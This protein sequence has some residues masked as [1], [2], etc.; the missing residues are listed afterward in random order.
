MH[1]RHSF[2]TLIAS[3]MVVG[4]V[5]VAE[6][7]V[8]L[9]AIISDSMV[10][11]QGRPVTIW[12]WAEPGERITIEMDGKIHDSGEDLD[13]PLYPEEITTTAN[14]QGRWKAVLRSRESGEMCEMTLTDASG[15][16]TTI[17]N[18]LTGEVWLCSGQS[19]MEMPVAGVNN[20]KKEIAAAKYPNIRFFQV[21]NATAVKPQTDCEGRWVE[22]SPETVGSH[23]AVGYFFGRE[24]FTKLNAPVGLIESDW[25]GTPAEA[26]TSREALDVQPSLAPLLARWDKTARK[27]T[28]QATAPHRPAN[29]YNAMIAPIA[30]YTIRG[31]IWYQ[32]ESNTS[33]AYQYRT[34]FPTMIAD[35]RERFKQPDMPFGFVQIAPYRYTTKNNKV[36]HRWCAELWE[37][38]LLTLKR[39]RNTGMVVTTDIGEVKNIHPKNKQEVGRR[40]ALWALARVYGKQLVYSGPIYKSMAVECDKIRLCFDHIDGGLAS[41]DGK[42]LTEFTIAGGDEKFHSATAEIDGDTIVV[43]SDAVKKPIAVRFAW[44]ETAQPN[45]VNKVGLP[46]SPFR[47]DD[48]KCLTEGRE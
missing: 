37:A 11:Q 13:I 9:P 12:G 43:K 45:L 10:L 17:K 34:I 21:K 24:L 26:W 20:S 41:R 6:A 32:G 30:P 33:R 42:P 2:Y 48:W 39:V 29:L 1:C 5:S 15:E 19:N 14:A 46:V 8:K 28:K 18:I 38:Q 3:L 36:D 4:F 40:L 23:T 27:Q 16:K 7:K 47:T 22:C 35:W 44:C 25:G 31:A